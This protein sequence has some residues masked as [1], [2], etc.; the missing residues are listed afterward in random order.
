MR[1][2]LFQC[3]ELVMWYVITAPREHVMTAA[4]SRREAKHMHVIR[5][6][7]QMLLKYLQAR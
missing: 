3:A 7:E 5:I 4:I 2:N 6:T 1:C